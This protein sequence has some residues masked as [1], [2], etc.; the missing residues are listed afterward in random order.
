MCFLGNPVNLKSGPLAMYTYFL[1]G[2]WHKSDLG[3]N[4]IGTSLRQ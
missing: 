2:M 1:L 4:L 3:N